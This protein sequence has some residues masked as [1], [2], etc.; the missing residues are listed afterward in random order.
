MQI[1]R[2]Q[3]Q[4]TDKHE[5]GC[6]QCERAER[7]RKDSAPCRR[8]IGDLA[9]IGRDLNRHFYALSLALLGFAGARVLAD[10]IAILR[11]NREVAYRL[12]S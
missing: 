11:E 1:D 9:A 10:T 12:N 3:C 8:S 7:H 4:Q 2:D 5:L 6:D